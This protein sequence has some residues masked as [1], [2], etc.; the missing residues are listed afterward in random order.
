M[1]WS[2]SSFN[3]VLVPR[4]SFPESFSGLNLGHNLPQLVLNIFLHN[5][6]NFPRS[7]ELPFCYS[8]NSWSVLGS[9]INSLSVNLRWIVKIEEEHAKLLKRNLIW[10]KLDSD[11]FCMAGRTTA[12]LAVFWIVNCSLLVATCHFQYTCE[13]AE[14]VLYTP[15]APSCEVSGFNA[16]SL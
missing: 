7:L 13:L 4:L 11:T 6:L 14:R 16:L 1:T 8:V 5:L 9:N 2:F 12:N 15:K 3:V 10:I